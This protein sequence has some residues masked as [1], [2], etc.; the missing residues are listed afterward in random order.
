MDFD[1]CLVFHANFPEFPPSKKPMDVEL[2]PQVLLALETVTLSM[3]ST[4]R[5][6]EMREMGP[7]EMAAN[8][9]VPHGQSTWHS[10]QKVG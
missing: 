5:Y 8:K 3:Q 6:G 1:G 4:Q 9:H 10:P 2:A 7:L